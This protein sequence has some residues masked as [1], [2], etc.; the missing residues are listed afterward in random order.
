[1]T[2]RRFTAEEEALF[3]F[4][5]GQRLFSTAL[6]GYVLGHK[7]PLSAARDY[8][9]VQSVP[10]EGMQR[11]ACEFLVDV[12][13]IG[14]EGELDLEGL[15]EKWSTAAEWHPGAYPKDRE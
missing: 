5:L 14:R 6:R 2:K 1:M 4:W 7:R 12:A 3:F 10:E 13:K 8:L 9:R 11:D 15:F